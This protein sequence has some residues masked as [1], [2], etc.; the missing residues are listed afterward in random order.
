MAYLTKKQA[1][2]LHNLQMTVFAWADRVFS[3]TTE[4]NVPFMQCLKLCDQETRDN[5]AN[6][7]AAL[8]QFEARMIAE[9]RGYPDQWGHFKPNLKA[10]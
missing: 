2:E 9:G 5:H 1:L 8:R 6:A 4:T 7:L 3:V 10:A